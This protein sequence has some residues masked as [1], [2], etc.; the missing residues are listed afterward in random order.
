MY[1]IVTRQLASVVMRANLYL[2]KSVSASENYAIICR[3]KASALENDR[4]IDTVVSCYLT[5]EIFKVAWAGPFKTCIN[6][7]RSW[8]DY[9]F[10]SMHETWLKVKL[11]SVP[12]CSRKWG[13]LHFFMNRSKLCDIGVKV[14]CGKFTINLFIGLLDDRVVFAENHAVYVSVIPRLF[15]S[16]ECGEK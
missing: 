12:Q 16:S 10:F 8:T 3:E 9:N 15:H 11:S 13:A 6:C 7:L 14:F 5:V 1:D 4:E 2:N